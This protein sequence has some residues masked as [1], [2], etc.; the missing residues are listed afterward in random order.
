MKMTNLLLLLAG[1]AISATCALAQE[2]AS[3]PPDPLTAI[4]SYKM[5]DSREPLSV[6]QDL[7]KAALAQPE[8]KAALAA[9]LATL[10]GSDAT[11]ECKRF[12]CRQLALIGGPAE[13]PLLA[14][15]LTEAALSDMARFALERIPFAEADAALLEALPACSG[16]IQ[17]GLVNS[18]GMRQCA[19]AVAPLSEMTKAEDAALA[20]A[21]VSALGRIGTPEACAALEALLGETRPELVLALHDA[22]LR[23]ADK[24]LA[25]GQRTDAIRIYNNLLE[26]PGQARVAAF[27]G[28]VTALGDEG[29]DLVLLR[30]KDG[31]P[32]FR[33]MA[34]HVARALA[35]DAVTRQ[36]AESLPELDASGQVMLLDVLAERGGTDARSAALTALE[37][38]DD[39]VRQA[40]LAALARLGTEADVMMLARLAA[41]TKGDEQAAVQ[42]ILA[43]LPGAA[44]D[45]EILANLD[46]GEQTIRR[47]LI[48][49]T[50]ARH[51]AAA[52]PQLLS[53]AQAPEPELH[54]AALLALAELATPA[55]FDALA[56]LLQAIPSETGREL[57]QSAMVSVLKRV[58]DEQARNAPV[59]AALNAATDVMLRVSLL[60]VLGKLGDAAALPAL[61]A[62]LQD[63]EENVRLAAAGALADWPR[64]E[65]TGDLAGVLA[66]ET[67]AAVRDRALRGYLRLLA[68]PGAMPMRDVLARH[69]QLL[70][71]AAS[72]EE[73]KIVLA[74]F[75][76]VPCIAALR[77]VAP[78]L[79]DEQFRTEAIAAALD[80]A[81]PL[82]GA[83]RSE[84]EAMLA[85]I[86]QLTSDPAAIQRIE[87]VR[88]LRARFEDFVMGWE[89][90]GPFSETGKNMSALVETAF[91]PEDPAANTVEWQ[92][93]PVGT[94]ANRPWLLDLTH[95]AKCDNCVAYLRTAIVAPETVQALM[96]LGSDDSVKVWLNGTLVHT[97]NE[98]RGAAPDT[99]RVPV[100][101][102][103]GENNLLLKVVNGGAGWGACI[104]FRT[105][106]GGPLPG[107]TCLVK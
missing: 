50:A 29:V 21:A 18:L 100:T 60:N 62:A 35:G 94:D 81:A 58:T 55:D 93:L 44:V 15:L 27:Q 13:V 69:E 83:Y 104:R 47:Q 91:P 86:A 78:Y 67:T 25:D 46:A 49:A 105:A 65:A 12:V 74:A 39:A 77:A 51:I 5:G 68:M 82:S 92:V 76:Q 103:A 48:A 57:L 89:I 37:S 66:Q 36:L 9:R 16:T 54:E 17:I 98:S 95:F 53:L 59:L 61:R 75:G 107:L 11:I 34:I 106:D 80:L 2:P 22:L 64:A 71:S 101:L 6:V 70:A 4:T 73:K 96:Q 26:T 79:D 14:P 33:E 28:M 40:A 23:C 97:V 19:N 88:T 24:L 102:N 10:L 32:A 38:A 41:G 99:D 72:L 7:V 63:P 1:L 3:A 20:E 45:Q 8:G 31:D 30:L 42:R 43:R 85:R 84:V 90:A 56:G 87:A 52:I